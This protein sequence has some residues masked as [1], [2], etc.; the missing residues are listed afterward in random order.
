MQRLKRLTGRAREVYRSGGLPGLLRRGLA[1]L[2]RPLFEHRAYYL[3]GYNLENLPQLDEA[4]FMPRVDG[5]ALRVVC[6]NE[7][8]DALE[9]EGF[10]FAPATGGF[11]FDARKALDSGAV[12]FCTYVGKELASIGWVALTQQAMDSLNERPMRVDFSGGESFTGNIWT[13]SKY[14]GMGL[15]LYRMH[16]KRQLLAEKGIKA[17][18]GY[19]AKRNV[20]AVRGIGRI[21]S[22]VYGE[23]R[24]LRVLWWRS[25]KE[26]PLSQ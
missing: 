23:G 15:R 1:F 5:F 8:A 11:R 12:A 6:S 4:R 21:D 13:N 18:R 26:R 16:K 2:L 10:E 24:Y 20:D 9:A 17:T 22:A 25:W 3:T 14:R 19:A 7:E